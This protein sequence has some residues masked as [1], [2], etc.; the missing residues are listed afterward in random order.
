M[1]LSNSEYVYIDVKIQRDWKPETR[2]AIRWVKD[3]AGNHRG[4]DR[5]VNADT[6]ESNITVYGKYTE[7]E[8]FIDFVQYNRVN[9]TNEIEISNFNENEK[10][11]G[12]DVDYSGTINSTVLSVGR[13]QQKTISTFSVSCSIRA[14][15]VAFSSTAAM[16]EIKHLSIGYDGDSDISTLKV[17]TQ[18]GKFYYIDDRA[19]AGIFE[20]E[21]SLKNADAAALRRYIATQRANT[22]SISSISGV[23]YPFGA[24]R[25]VT[26]PINCKIIDWDDGGMWGQHYT[27][28]K[29]KLAEVI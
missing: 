20:G 8:T 18:H 16:P 25:S 7:V 9:G 6:Y 5:G 4:I 10:I 15:D 14:I 12:G 3:A 11:F 2:L 28:F 19:D 13:I 1:R 23:Q 24:R 27:I 26:F 21:L 22:V 17:D 29:I